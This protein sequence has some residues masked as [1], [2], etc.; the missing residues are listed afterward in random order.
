MAMEKKTLLET[1]KE[2]ASL[3][4]KIDNKMAFDNE[5]CSCQ[6]ACDCVCICDCDTYDSLKQ[7]KEKALEK[8]YWKYS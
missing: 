8:N 5:H 6:C 1:E 7:N 3:I 4:G 2:K